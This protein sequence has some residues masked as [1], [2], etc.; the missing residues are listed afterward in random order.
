MLLVQL[1]DEVSKTGLF[2]PALKKSVRNLSNEATENVSRPVFCHMKNRAMF[3]LKQEQRLVQPRAELQSRSRAAAAGCA[4]LGFIK[5]FCQCVTFLPKEERGAG[6]TTTTTW[7]RLLLLSKSQRLIKN[8]R[9]CNTLGTFSLSV[10]M[11]T[12][13][14]TPAYLS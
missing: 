2:V 1:L 8:S 14:K 10:A 4:S 9:P 13:F 11:V 7:T 6:K 12:S 5:N 3:Y